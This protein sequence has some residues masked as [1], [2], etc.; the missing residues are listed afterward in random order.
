MP[1]NNDLYSQVLN[2]I[3]ASP[4]EWDQASWCGT[5]CCF[6]GHAGALVGYTNKVYADGSISMIMVDPVTK[7]EKWVDELAT[8]RLGLTPAQADYLFESV[9][10]IQ[11]FEEFQ[12]NI[13]NDPYYRPETSFLHDHE[14]EE[15]DYDVGN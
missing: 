9:R 5:S 8:E 2:K 4:A 7:E 3:K 15:D 13:L 14:C 12:F 1:F 10:T 6:A 11:D